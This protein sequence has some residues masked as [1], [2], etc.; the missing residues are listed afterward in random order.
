MPTGLLSGTVIGAGVF[1]L[2]FV[3][4]ISG[5]ST[6]LFYLALAAYLYVFI[7]LF[8]ADVI[9]RTPGEHRFVG[10][11]QIYLGKLAGGLA[12]LMSV[13]EMIFVLTIYLVLSLSF[14]NLVIAPGLALLKILI[15]WILGS[16]AIFFSLKKI[17][18]LE[19]LIAW[20]MTAIIVL[21]FVFG[22]AQLEKIAVADFY[23]NFVN[24]FLPLGPILFALGGRVAIP[25]VI[26]YFKLPGIGHNQ[27]LVKR[28]I[29]FGTLIPALVYGLFIFGILGLSGEVSE[30]AVSGLIGQ[31]PNL[32]LVVMGI[33]GILALWSSYI[34][35]G[36]DVLNTLRYDLK[37]SQT[38]RI[39]LVVGSPLLLYFLSSQDFIALVSFVGG[40]LLAL[41]GIFI[42]AMWLKVNT[43]LK[44]APILVSKTNFGTIVIAF[45]VLGAALVYEIIKYL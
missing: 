45:L 29:I 5:L 20:G 10:Y 43:S 33:L 9:L 23:P 11:A 1:A 14:I 4:Q 28:A 3:F 24:L 25:A 35:I 26:K 44:Q 17:A 8:Y 31:V 22:L 13:L 32:F 19:F 12:I 34:I 16:A 7:H 39:L 40:T 42:I 18:F 15:F 41:E 36:F 37:L 2:P 6:G 27:V 38:V 21:I 30:D